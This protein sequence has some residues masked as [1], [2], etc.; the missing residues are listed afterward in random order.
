MYATAIVCCFHSDCGVPPSYPNAIITTGATTQGTQ[1]QYVCKANYYTNS[2]AS[3]LVTTC[4][5]NTTWNTPSFSCVLGNVIIVVIL[6]QEIIIML[7]SCILPL[8]FA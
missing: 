6:K 5:P 7:S 2:P 3:D 4:Q 1:R 8:P